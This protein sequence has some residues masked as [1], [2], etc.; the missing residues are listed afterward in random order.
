MLDKNLK[1]PG[2]GGSELAEPILKKF[3]KIFL[4]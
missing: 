4:H 2:I 1:V 3:S